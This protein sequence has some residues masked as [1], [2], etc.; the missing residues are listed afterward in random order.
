MAG[1]ALPLFALLQA[2][3][4]AP[5]VFNVGAGEWLP[6]FTSQES[7]DRYGQMSGAFGCPVLELASGAELGEFLLSPCG[8]GRAVQTVMLDPSGTADG[9]VALYSAEQL[10]GGLK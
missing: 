10:L 8:T 4:K 6:L 3:R 1:P 5:V 2:D 7:A 9:T